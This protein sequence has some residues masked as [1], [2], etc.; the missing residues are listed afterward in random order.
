MLLRQICAG[1]I[2]RPGPATSSLPS[3]NR[4]CVVNLSVLPQSRST[5]CPNTCHSVWWEQWAWGTIAAKLNTQ[6]GPQV[7]DPTQLTAAALQWLIIWCNIALTL[8]R[9]SCQYEI[10]NLSKFIKL[11]KS[12]LKS[13]RRK[14][15][16]FFDLKSQKNRKKQFCALLYSHYKLVYS[17]T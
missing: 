16:I 3:G 13:N 17:H 11:Q 12:Q 9:S 1:E 14:M 5:S 2:K 6:R 15:W 4:A 8:H 10:F 7:W